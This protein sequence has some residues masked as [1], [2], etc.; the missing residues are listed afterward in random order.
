MSIYF[1]T[2]L[3]AT[4]ERK[5]NTAIKMGDIINIYQKSRQ[6]KIGQLLKNYPLLPGNLSQKDQFE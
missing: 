4:K 6:D 2:L 3:C 5:V 1:F